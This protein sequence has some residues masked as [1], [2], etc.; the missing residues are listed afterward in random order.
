MNLLRA[1]RKIG[2]LAG[3]V[4]AGIG[5][6]TYYEVTPGVYQ[7]SAPTKFDRAWSA[8]IGAFEDQ[9]VQIV[10]QDR[11]A[12]YLRG[13]RDGIDVTATVRTQADGSVR[14]QFDTSGAT[15][16]D[17]TLINRVDRAYERLMGR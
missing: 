13:T 12:G 4:I 16:R 10:A 3:L 2:V 14:V 17:P 11:D 5:G 9:G 8:A 6:C 7:T 15:N 1:G